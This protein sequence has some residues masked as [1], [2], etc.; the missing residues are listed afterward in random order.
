MN[1]VDLLKTNNVD[2]EASLELWG[3]MDTYNGGLK[4]FKDSLPSK[5]ADLEAYKNAGD[6]ENYAILAHSMKSEAKYLG[7]MKASEVFLEHEL[8][9]KANDR[10]FIEANFNNLKETINKMLYILVNTLMKIRKKIF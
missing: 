9:G 6:W 5:L 1:K 10:L 8:K 7:F 3:D 2:V 4:E